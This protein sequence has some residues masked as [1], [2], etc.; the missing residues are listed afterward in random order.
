M[1]KQQ[2]YTESQRAKG[3]VLVSVWVHETLRQRL[4][5]YAAKLKKQ[6]A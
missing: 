6:R 4:I 2:R 5:K 3:L 1:N